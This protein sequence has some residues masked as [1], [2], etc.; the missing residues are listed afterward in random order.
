M[1]LAG[2]SGDTRR[3]M[4]WTDWM[5]MPKGLLIS[6][7]MPA[8]KPPTDIIFSAWTSISWTRARSVTSS[9]RTTA[10]STPLV[11]SG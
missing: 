9:M 6:W 2:K 11:I 3:S 5:M 4:F 10:P 8:A 7:A 1:R